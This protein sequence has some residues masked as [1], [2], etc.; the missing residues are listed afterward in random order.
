MRRPWLMLVC[1]I[2]RSWTSG[3]RVRSGGNTC[4]TLAKRTMTWDTKML[5]KEISV[6]FKTRGANFSPTR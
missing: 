2:G 6:L 3:W 5:R 1:M 4:S